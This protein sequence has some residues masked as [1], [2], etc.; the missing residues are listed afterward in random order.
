MTLDHNVDRLLLSHYRSYIPFLVQH[1]LTSFKFFP[2]VARPAFAQKSAPRFN[3]EVNM[4]PAEFEAVVNNVAASS[5][6]VASNVSD[7]GGYLFPVFGIGALCALIL[8]LS[9]PLSD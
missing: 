8:Y 4:G 6:V 5:N 2:T 7:F 3:T 9:P 1:A